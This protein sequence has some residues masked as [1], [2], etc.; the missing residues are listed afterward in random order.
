MMRKA[1]SNVTPPPLPVW[2]RSSDV[3]LVT[4]KMFNMIHNIMIEWLCS[5]LNCVANKKMSNIG[6]K[7]MGTVKLSDCQMLWKRQCITMYS[8][9]MWNVSKCILPKRIKMYHTQV[10]C[11]T[12][13]QNLSCSHNLWKQQCSLMY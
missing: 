2:E 9:E 5:F 6:L 12:F 11:I 3:N 13:Y 8:T 7:K 10:G 1:C 4:N